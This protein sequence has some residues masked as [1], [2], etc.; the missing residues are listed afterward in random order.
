MNN[1]EKNSIN[2]DEKMTDKDKKRNTS[3]IFKTNKEEKM[4]ETCGDI[5]FWSSP[6][7]RYTALWSNIPYKF[8]KGQRHYTPNDLYG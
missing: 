8:K 5:K 4:K 2:E 3:N 7:K 1:E 6:I